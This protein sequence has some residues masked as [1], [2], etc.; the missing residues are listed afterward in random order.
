MSATNIF[1]CRLRI[2][3]FLK[4]ESGVIHC[5]LK[6]EN[7]VFENSGHRAG[8]KVTDFGV[9]KRLQA[10]KNSSVHESGVGTM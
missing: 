8:I 6:F 4:H 10:G 1:A 5:D 3:L 7:I 9:A 2:A